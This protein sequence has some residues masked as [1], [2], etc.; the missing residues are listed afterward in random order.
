MKTLNAS[1]ISLEKFHNKIVRV[2]LTYEESVYGIVVKL[3][4]E[5]FFVVDCKEK[6]SNIVINGRS[7][8]KNREIKCLHD[9][10]PIPI[11]R[12]I[13]IKYCTIFYNNEK[14][15][16]KIILYALRKH[17]PQLYFLY[18]GN[19]RTCRECKNFKSSCNHCNPNK[20]ACEDFK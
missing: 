19:I 14:E 12:I 13:K 4:K 7:F 8:E 20:L 10:R 11:D 1:E 16:L 3:N 5:E 18:K 2:D 17:F 15:D 9:L 6:S